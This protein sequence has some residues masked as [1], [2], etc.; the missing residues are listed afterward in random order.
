VRR[1]IEDEWGGLTVRNGYIQRSVAPP[2]FLDASRFYAWFKSH[3]T[4]LLN[5][6]N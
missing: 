4:I 3:G 6:N 5:R 2:A 1:D